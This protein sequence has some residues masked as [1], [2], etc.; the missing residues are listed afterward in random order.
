MP[1]LTP[2]PMRQPGVFTVSVMTYLTERLTR[3]WTIT[4]AGHTATGRLRLWQTRHPELAEF[5]TVAE[6]AETIRT[7]DRPAANQLVTILLRE[8][9]AGDRLARETILNALRYLAIG[10]WRTVT[11]ELDR[12]A[13]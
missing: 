12:E 13:T 7:T 3:G 1:R 4:A 6:L 11:P 9:G 2:R 5:T 10:V 8:A